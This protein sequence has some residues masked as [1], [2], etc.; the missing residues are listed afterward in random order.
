VPKI[1][2]DQSLPPLPDT[3]EARLEEETRRD[4]AAIIA[5][6]R[7]DRGL[8]EKE[9]LLAR[10]IEQHPEFAGALEQAATYRPSGDLDG[11]FLHVAL[12]RVVEQRVVTRQ[13]SLMTK[14]AADKPWHE[15]VHEA[16]EHVVLELFGADAVAAGGRSQS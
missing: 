2:P 8:D 13:S 11:P 5:A 14:F 4:V 1:R 7:A 6:R 3:D 10:I 9:R 16:I 12:H 15:A